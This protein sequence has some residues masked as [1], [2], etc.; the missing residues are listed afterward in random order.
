[1]GLV[2]RRI[3]VFR[4]RFSRRLVRKSLILRISMVIRS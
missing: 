1:M 2:F 4:V 3:S